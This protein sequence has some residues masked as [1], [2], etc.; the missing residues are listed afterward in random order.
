MSNRYKGP[1]KVKERQ[2]KY[3]ILE[4]PNQSTDKVSVDRLVPFYADDSSSPDY[5]YYNPGSIAV[6]RS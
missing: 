3:F 5:Y 2:P 4:L 1:F 6:I